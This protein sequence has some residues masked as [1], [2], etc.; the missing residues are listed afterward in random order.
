MINLHQKPITNQN[1]LEYG[2]FYL[3]NGKKSDFSYNIVTTITTL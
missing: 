3:G 1:H 2:R